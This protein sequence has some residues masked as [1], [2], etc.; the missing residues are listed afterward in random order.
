MEK[1]AT[2]TQGTGVDIIKREGERGEISLTASEEA[3]IY[4]DVWS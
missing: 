4:R 1:N 2:R 3:K